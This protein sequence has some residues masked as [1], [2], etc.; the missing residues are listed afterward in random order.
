MKLLLAVILSLSLISCTPSEGP[1][2][3]DIF[4]AQQDIESCIRQPNQYQC[5]VECKVHPKREFCK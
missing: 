1:K 3:P 2:Q 5:K 4:Y